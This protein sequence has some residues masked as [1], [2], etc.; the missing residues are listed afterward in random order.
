M[1]PFPTNN[2]SDNTRA[3]VY[4]DISF[5]SHTFI[6]L[7]TVVSFVFTLVDSG[8]HAA[9]AANGFCITGS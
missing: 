9:A 4:K 6:L 8:R 5:Y 7:L 3:E 1:P 2:I